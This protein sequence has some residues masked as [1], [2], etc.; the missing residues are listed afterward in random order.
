MADLRGVL[1]AN[2]LASGLVSPNGPGNSLLHAARLGRFAL[3]VSPY[4]LGE[5]SRTL[6][7]TFLVPTEDAAA[8]VTFVMGISE[9]QEPAAVARISRDPDDDPILAL[10]LD[11]GAA[12]LATYDHD[13]MAV[14]SVGECGVVHPVTALQL[15][16]AAST[17]EV[18][19][20]GIP[21]VS[22]E[23]RSSW[24]YEEGGAALDA[25]HTFVEWLRGLPAERERGHEM[26]TPESWVTLQQAIADG[27]AATVAESITHWSASVRHPADGMAYVF[28]PH[29]HPDQDEVFLVP[30]PTVMNVTAITLVWRDSRWLVHGVGPLV[31]PA[32]VGLK[33]Y[34]W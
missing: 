23:D 10:A 27:S 4:L 15:V 18:A 21:G 17:P 7:E 1:D 2:L 25:A 24:R 16:A 6:E 33:A 26:V 31:P 5:V 30:G 12:F 19:R 8:L 3:M 20:E 11:S 14:G 29:V 9:A 34:S 22:A 13:L 28:C 32:H